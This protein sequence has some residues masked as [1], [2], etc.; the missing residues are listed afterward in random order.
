MGAESEASVLH[1][2]GTIHD[3]SRGAALLAADLAGLTLVVTKYP[4]M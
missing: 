2:D 1:D 4:P 3:A